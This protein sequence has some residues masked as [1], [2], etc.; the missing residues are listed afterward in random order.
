[1]AERDPIRQ[2]SGLPGP[3]LRL[4]IPPPDFPRRLLEEGVASYV[5][6]LRRH[7]F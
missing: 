2:L 7:P 6:W 4:L 3:A 5:D 1:M